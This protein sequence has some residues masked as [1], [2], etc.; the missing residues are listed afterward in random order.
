MAELPV[1]VWPRIDP[2]EAEAEFD[3]LL[4]GG[5]DEATDLVNLSVDSVRFYETGAFRVDSAKLGDLREK[6][7][8]LASHYGFPSAIVK[9]NKLEF[10]RELALVFAQ[11]MPM[12]EVEASLA[13]VWNFL[14]LRV[15]PDVAIWRWPGNEPSAKAEVEGGR[16]RVHRLKLVRRN[17][18]RQAWFRQDLLGVEACKVFEEDEFVQLTDRITLLGNSFLS[19]IIAQEAIRTKRRSGYNR[20]VLRRGLRLVGQA[21]G[22]IAV[23]ALSRD[24][25]SRMIAD[26]FDRAFVEKSKTGSSGSNKNGPD[27]SGARPSI[28]SSRQPPPSGNLSVVE[29]DYLRL[30]GDHRRMVMN[31]LGACDFKEARYLLERSSD[32][33][34]G[35]FRPHRSRQ[36]SARLEML[37]ENWA[38]LSM[39]QQ[40]VAASALRI[41]AYNTQTETTNRFKDLNVPERVINAAYMALGM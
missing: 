24:V 11:E 16:Q 9:D 38:S 29:E 32:V 37:I 1:P 13:Q 30:A 15:L 14:T 5:V 12:L 17:V 2:S 3:V 36:L 40:S 31:T 7:I 21:C 41:S 28:E 23:E 20:E 34:R 25:V 10:D 22:R 19:Q 4:N 6:V 33:L 35:N 8:R 39:S 18:F 27:Y 26:C